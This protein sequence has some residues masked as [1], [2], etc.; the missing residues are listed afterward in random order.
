VFNTDLMCGAVTHDTPVKVAFTRR[1]RFD[2][3]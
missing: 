1:K 3:R 2:A